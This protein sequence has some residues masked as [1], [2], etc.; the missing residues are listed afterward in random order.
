MDSNVLLFNSPPKRNVW[1]PTTLETF[2]LYCQTFV[3][4]GSSVVPVPGMGLLYPLIPSEGSKSGVGRVAR[5]GRRTGSAGGHGGL[6]SQVKLVM[7]ITALAL[8]A[9]S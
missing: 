6:S 8:L 2:A 4:F 9:R 5:G 3:K 1:L 7:L